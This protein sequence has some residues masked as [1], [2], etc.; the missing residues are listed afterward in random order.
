MT[1]TR[2][3]WQAPDEEDESVTMIYEKPARKLRDR[4]GARPIKLE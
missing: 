3:I 4:E 2:E 1:D